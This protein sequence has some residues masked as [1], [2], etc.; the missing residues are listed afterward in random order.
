MN[1]QKT[2]VPLDIPNFEE[3]QSRLIPYMLETYPNRMT[4]WNK[5]DKAALFAHVPELLTA[6]KKATGQQPFD[7]YLLA[8]PNAPEMILKNHLDAKSLHADTSIESCRLNWPILNGTSLE[9]RMFRTSAEPIK[10]V[11]ETGETYLTYKEEDCKLI[12]SFFLTQPVIMSVHTIHGLYRTQGPLPRYV[13]SF[14]FEPDIPHLL[15]S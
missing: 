14:N 11:L 4:F 10:K 9:T 8:V 5:V 3:I 2:F 1:M 13:L 6:V 15:N 12:E 7:A